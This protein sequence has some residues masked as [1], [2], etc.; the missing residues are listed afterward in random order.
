[1]R[2]LWACFL[3]VI[4]VAVGKCS[5]TEGISPKLLQTFLSYLPPQAPIVYLRYTDEIMPDKEAVL[6]GTGLYSSGQNGRA[7]HAAKLY[8]FVK[9]EQWKLFFSTDMDE[10]LKAWG[11]FGSGWEIRLRRVV[12]ANLDRDKQKEIV[13]FWSSEPY[14]NISSIQL[15]TIIHV[16]D[17]DV[18][19]Q[20]FREVTDGR[21]VYHWVYEKA[22]LLNVD[23]DYESEI[24]LFRGDISEDYCIFCGKPYYIEV[25]T[26]RNGELM[27][28][29]SWN[30]GQILKVKELL[31]VSE[32]EFDNVLDCDLVTLLCVVYG[33]GLDNDLLRNTDD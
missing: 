1:M 16:L 29:P 33:Q 31:N 12:L 26:L 8:I 18:E 30:D 17:Y 22:L 9:E 25:W 32:E 23:C 28:D 27:L 2:N 20:R 13:I 7:F 14:A 10:R 3:C 24:V 6:L 4:L 11:L 19:L 5:A 21:L 15:Q